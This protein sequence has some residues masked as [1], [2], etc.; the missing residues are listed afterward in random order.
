LRLPPLRERKEDIPLLV[1][2]FL[3]KFSTE[4]G[5]PFRAITDEALCTLLAYHWPG[6]VRELANVIERA[7]VL[8]AMPVA[9]SSEVVL[10]TDAVKS[11]QTLSYRDGVNAARKDLLQKALTKTHGNRAAAARLLDLETKYFLKLIK[12]LGIE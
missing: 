3:K 4:T 5:R 6:N 2:Y 1:N 7:V 9:N 11:D 12:S 10:T 8:G